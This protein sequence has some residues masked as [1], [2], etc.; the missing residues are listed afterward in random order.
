M[1]KIFYGSIWCDPKW[2]RRPSDIGRSFV[3]LGIAMRTKCKLLVGGI[4]TILLA[5]TA[6]ASDAKI[7]FKL[8][9]CP[10]EMTLFATEAFRGAVLQDDLL[11]T[12]RPFLFAETRGVFATRAPEKPDIALLVVEPNRAHEVQGT[13]SAEQFSRVKEAMLAKSP[14]GAVVDANEILKERDTVINEYDGIVQ[15]STDTSATISLVLDGTATGADFTSLTGFKMI[16]SDKCLVGVILIAPKATLARRQFE[17][18]IK[19]IVIE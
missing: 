19:K 10:T 18:M 16:Y 4:A 13:V 8:P 5:Q 3:V 9:N 2:E 14:S 17:E 15:S 11:E 6:L 7:R 1:S 12:Y